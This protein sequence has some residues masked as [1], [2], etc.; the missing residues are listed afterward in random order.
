MYLDAVNLPYKSDQLA[1][2]TRL[3]FEKL[4]RYQVLDR[5][6]MRE[7]VQKMGL[8]LENCYSKSCV[9]QAGK[10]LKANY[11][12]TGTAEI[13]ASQLIITMRLINVETDAIEKT[14]VMEFLNLPEQIRPMIHV[15]IA[16]LHGLP[17][18]QDTLRKLTLPFD[19][20]NQ[21]NNPEYGKINS[22]GPRMGM[23]AFTGS[24]ARAFR[25]PKSQG[26]YNARPYMFQ[27]G[28]QFEVSYLN[29]GRLQALFEF[30]PIITGLDQS[31]M[32]PTLSV[33]NGVRD[34]KTGL[35]FAFGPVLGLDKTVDGYYTDQG[36][37]VSKLDADY[38]PNGKNIVQRLDRRADASFTSNFVFGIGR[39]FKS[40]RVNFPVNFFYIPNRGGDRFGIS[41]GYNSRGRRTR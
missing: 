4:D 12:A 39:T 36:R 25:D 30:I 23:T 20:D 9:V 40:G 26:G 8:A 32:L 16:H 15:T 11:I 1:S 37:W 31:L 7:T 2:I 18:N 13:L 33:L 6:E 24:D 35:E 34:N 10:Q 3:E 22:S 41:V 29:E 14:Q 28:Y 27:L 19:Y 21:L 17:I 5:Y 38:S